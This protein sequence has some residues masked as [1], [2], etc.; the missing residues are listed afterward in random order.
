MALAWHTR[1]P[2]GGIFNKRNARLIH[3]PWSGNR[4][5]FASWAWTQ[6]ETPSTWALPG[7]TTT[8]LGDAAAT[9][10]TITPEQAGQFYQAMSPQDARTKALALQAQIA[11]LQAEKANNPWMNAFGILDNRIRTLQAELA[12]AQQNAALQTQGDAATA[13]WRKIGQTLG[14]VGIALGVTATIALGLRFVVRR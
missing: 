3:A 4:P 1:H 8:G 7:T 12:A 11:N 13:D 14:L 6:L 10:L 2:R 9:G 5:V